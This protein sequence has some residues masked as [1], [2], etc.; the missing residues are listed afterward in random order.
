M[1]FTRV[2]TALKRAV[3]AVPDETS[4]VKATTLAA[5][6]GSSST[7]GS[8]EEEFSPPP[9]LIRVAEG[10]LAP[11]SVQAYALAARATAAIERL[12]SKRRLEA[13]IHA[14]SSPPTTETYENAPPALGASTANSK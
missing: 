3:A 6:S 13:T 9:I 5:A 12:Y 2:T 8:F 10:L 1:R 7:S 11:T 4:H 14:G